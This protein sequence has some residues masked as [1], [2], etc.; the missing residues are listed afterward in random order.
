MQVLFVHQNFPGQYK[1]L[2]PALASIPGVR[3]AAL[4]MGR[5]PDLP[6]VS[7]IQHQPKRGNS[8]NI[9]PLL[10]ETETKLI[11]GQATAEVAI[12]LRK[13]GFKP[14]VICAHPGW[15][16]AMFLKDVFPEAKLLNFFEYYYQSA[17]GDV[18]FDPEFGR[19][20][21]EERMRLRMKNIN[22]LVALDAADWGIS[23]T[24]WQ[25]SVA[26]VEYQPKIS[27]IHDGVDTDAIRPDIEARFTLPNGRPLSRVDEVITFVARNLEPYRG[28]HIFMRALPKILRLR[29]NAQI[30]VIG[31]DEVSY[32]KKL[33]DGKS[34]KEMYL[35]EIGASVDLARV[36]FVGRLAH[37]DFHNALRVSSAHVYLTY[38]FVLSWSLLESMAL[39]CL[40]IGSRTAPVQEVIEHGKNGFLVD[41]FDGE[42][43][44]DQI[45]DALRHQADFASLRQAARQTVVNHYD[46]RRIC[47]PQQVELIKKL[48]TGGMP[49]RVPVENHNAFIARHFRGNTSGLAA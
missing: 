5:S 34:Y 15:G 36:H 45:D 49:E 6:G 22:N 46:L 26:P 28:F 40:V 23:P 11:R 47:L 25:R 7:Y 13:N 10:Q 38:P 42:A 1:H 32:G 35:R 39:E 24:F 9:Q 44:A 17:G 41:F 4:G 29:P 18:G 37:G 20:G 2:A 12:K 30:V 43:L 27:V 21:I 16:E 8:P 19:T 33:P 3:V 31:G 48:G 14:H